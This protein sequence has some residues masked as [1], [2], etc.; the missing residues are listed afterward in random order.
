MKALLARCGLKMLHDAIALD[1]SVGEG[2]TTQ[3][4]LCVS[5]DVAAGTALLCE[6]APVL[7]SM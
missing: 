7:R 4:R 3:S 6:G 5:E 2:L 1:E